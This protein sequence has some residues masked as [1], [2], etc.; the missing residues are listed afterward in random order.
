[1]KQTGIVSAMIVAVATG[2]ETQVGAQAA[3][4]GPLRIEMTAGTKARYRVGEKLVGLN[5]TN[6]AVGSTE[7]VTGAIVLKADG[8]IDST[9]SKI[10]VDM[11]S[12]SSDQTMRDMFLQMS[13]LQTSKFPTLEFVPTKAVGLPNPLPVGT[14]M[15]NSTIV[16]PTPVGFQLTGNMTLHGVTKEVTWSI[17]ATMGPE[18]IAG[19][20][21]AK[22]T[23]AAFNM[24]KPVVPV[25]AS[26]EDDIS[27]ELEFRAK[28]VA[29]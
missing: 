23:F 28:R 10:V 17:V 1:V 4:A 24:T 16:L 26:A 13:V 12:L 11:K 18:A 15:P 2:A 19:R 8:S 7:A 20:G 22:I 6:D 21:T 29:Q 27:L 5:V 25:L 9:Q 3:Q 14:K